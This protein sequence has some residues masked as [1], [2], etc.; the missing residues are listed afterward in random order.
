MW[1]NI[2]NRLTDNPN[3]DE[4]NFIFS[5]NDFEGEYEIVDLK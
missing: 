3:A 4:V 2:I 1:K 5:R